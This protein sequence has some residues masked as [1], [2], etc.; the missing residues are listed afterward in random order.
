ML[1]GDLCL[2]SKGSKNTA[3]MFQRPPSALS[4]LLLISNGDVTFPM[5][6]HCNAR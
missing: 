4:V 1:F 5:Y 3:I 6:I 2:A